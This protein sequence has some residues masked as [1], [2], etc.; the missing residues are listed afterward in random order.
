[1][2]RLRRAWCRHFE[3]Q[4]LRAA[5]A[6]SDDERRAMVWGS[7][8]GF[9]IGAYLGAAAAVLLTALVALVARLVWP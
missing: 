6:L 8:G 9:V 1:M 7:W 4:V 3:A 5:P 2:T